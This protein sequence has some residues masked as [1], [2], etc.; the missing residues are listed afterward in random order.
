MHCS[1]VACKVITLAN[2]S[3]ICQK[4]AL[5]NVFRLRALH[6]SEELQMLQGIGTQQTYLTILFTRRNSESSGN[7][8]LC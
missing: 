3:A 4:T 8:Q 6:E 7:N 2:R 1:E 5:R